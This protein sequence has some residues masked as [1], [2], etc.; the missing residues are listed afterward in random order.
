MWERERTGGMSRPVDSP[1][2]WGGS[3]GWWVWVVAVWEC[4]LQ[5]GAGTG[6]WCGCWREWLLGWQSE[7]ACGGDEAGSKAAT[8]AV[9]PL[10]C[11]GD[12]VRASG[13]SLPTVLVIQLA[14][15]AGKTF[16]ERGMLG[17]MAGSRGVQG[18]W[19]SGPGRECGSGL[20]MD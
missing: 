7:V 4:R 11:C 16:D 18:P 15:A 14:T 19:F 1:S 10:G 2:P 17:R 20:V 3:G 13:H 9:S 12:G 5:G 6:W 8:E